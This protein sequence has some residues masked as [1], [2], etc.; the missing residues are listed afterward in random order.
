MKLEGMNCLVTGGGGNLGSYV[1]EKLLPLGAN[2]TVMERMSHDNQKLV[3]LKNVREK[4]VLQW[5]DIRSTRDCHQMAKDQD[6]IVHVA[7]SG[8]VPYS[9]DH[10]VE[11]WENNVNGTLNLLEA[12]VKFGVKRFLFINSSE[13]YGRAKYVPID[14]KHGFYPCSPYGASKAAGE[15]LGQSY[16]ESYGIQFISVRMFNMYGPRSVPYS[17]INKFIVLSL[18]NKPLPVAGNGEQKRDYVYTEDAAEGVVEALQ[19]DKM[20]GDNVNIGSGKSVSV[21]EIAKTIKKLTGSKSELQF[22]PGRPGELPILESDITKAKELLGWA[23][24]HSFEDGIKITI[25]HIKKN[26]GLYPIKQ[27]SKSL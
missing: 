19:S 24:K 22:F 25:D 10:P 2:V 9:I 11:V 23:P 3:N 1:V 15:M 12:A 6:I 20:V 5:G 21:L 13:S 18:D 8:P 16:Y 27:L 26:K 7:A 4:L 17:V 14:E